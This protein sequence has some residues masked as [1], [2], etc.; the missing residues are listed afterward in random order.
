M[1]SADRREQL[2]AIARFL[3]DRSGIHRAIGLP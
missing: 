3:A 2:I 1:S